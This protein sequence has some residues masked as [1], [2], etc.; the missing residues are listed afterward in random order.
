MR[1]VRD[2]GRYLVYLKAKPFYQRHRD[3]FDVVIDEINTR[4]FMTPKYVER[5][6]IIALIHQLAREFWF[7]ETRFPI[8]YLG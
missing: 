5:K 1:I 3:E 7:Y 4:P 2:G 8:N 6:K